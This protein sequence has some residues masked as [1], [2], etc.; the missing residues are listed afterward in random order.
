MEIEGDMS[1]NAASRDPRRGGAA[2]EFALVLP[3]FMALV[4]GALDYGYFF[5]VDQIVTNAARE[6]ARGGTLVDPVSAGAQARASADAK[7]IAEAY[8][9]RNGLSPRGVT[10]TIGTVVTANDAVD[11]LIRYPFQS[12]TGFTSIMVPRQIYAHAV[13]RWQ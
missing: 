11:V 2:V 12:L 10:A 13:M 6:G 4:M 5:Y 7:A 3:L 1:R 8:M 9:T